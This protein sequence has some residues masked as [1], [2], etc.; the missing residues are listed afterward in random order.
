MSKHIS[1]ASYEL[2]AAARAEGYA[3]VC[4]AD[5]AGAGP[6]M[7]PVYAAAVILPEGC[8]IEGLDDSKK[9]SE[10]K[11]KALFDIIRERAVAYSVASVDAREID[12]IDILN[13]RI[14]A[15]QLAIDG[16]NVKADFAL[17]DGEHEHRRGIDFSQGQ[18]RPLR[19]RRA[20]Q[21]ISAVSLCKA[22]GLWNPAALRHARRVRPLPLSPKD[23]SQKVGGGETMSTTREAGDRGEAMAAEYLREN[24]YE[25]LA[26]QFRCRFGEI[27]LIARRGDILCFVE[28]KLRSDRRF[29]LPRDFVTA[30][31]QRRIRTTAAFYMTR[32]DPDL[33]ARFDVAEVYDDET[34]P[35]IEYIENAFE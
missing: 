28:V 26:S 29:G 2:E 13:A 5:E 12:E 15:M 25:I 30:A 4:G 10:K 8:V 31:K 1:L 9:L 32:H 34:P 27:D 19:D 16:L 21:A 14:K 7:G 3:H 35:R 11:R 24:G 17:I 22:Q 6:L 18:P 23:F 20:G 33:C